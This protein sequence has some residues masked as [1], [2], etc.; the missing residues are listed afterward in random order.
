MSKRVLESDRL[1]T[2][3]AQYGQALRIWTY[4]ITHN[5]KADWGESRR[6][7][8]GQLFFEYLNKKPKLN[9][10]TVGYRLGITQN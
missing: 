2:Y 10:A 6:T 3:V 1:W 5:T 8:I 4:N 7:L 9:E